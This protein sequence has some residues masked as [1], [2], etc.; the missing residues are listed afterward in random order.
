MR[1]GE[2]LKSNPIAK[3]D[4][5]ITTRELLKRKIKATCR[6]LKKGGELHE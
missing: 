2:F 6:K 1:N 3:E 4:E 5:S